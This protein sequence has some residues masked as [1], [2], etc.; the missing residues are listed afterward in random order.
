MCTTAVVY[1]EEAWLPAALFHS[2]SK[3]SREGSDWL[4]LEQ[5]SVASRGGGRVT[6]FKIA[7]AM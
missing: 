1:R 6:L 4:S 5:T 3:I 7:A 2:K